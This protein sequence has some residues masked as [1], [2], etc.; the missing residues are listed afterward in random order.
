MDNNGHQFVQYLKRRFPD[1][2]PNLEK[3]LKKLKTVLSGTGATQ[4]AKKI[5]RKYYCSKCGRDFSRKFNMLRHEKKCAQDKDDNIV[6]SLYVNRRKTIDRNAMSGLANIHQ[7]FP[8]LQEMFDILV[9]MGNLKEEITHHLKQRCQELKHL[10]YYLNISVEMTRQTDDGQEETSKPHF[11]TQTKSV[12]SETDI[13]EHM[14]NE[15]FQKIFKSLDEYQR[16]GSSWTLKK[17]ICF[18]IYTAK[19]SPIGAGSF[20]E[21]PEKLRNTRSVINIKNTDEKCFLWSIL[22]A[23]HPVENNKNRVLHYERFEKTVNMD[24]IAYPVPP[25]SVPKFEKQNQISVNVF[26]YENNQVFPLYISAQ[27]FLLHVDLLFLTSNGQSH[28]CLIENFDRFMSHFRK[29]KGY[30]Y[31]RYCLQGFTSQRVLNNHLQFCSKKDAQY[32]TYPRKGEDDEL[33]FTEVAKQ[34]RVPFVIYADFETF[35]QTFD[36]CSPDPETSFTENQLKYEACGYGYQVVSLDAKYTKTPKIYRG[37][38]VSKHFLESMIAERDE[39][40]NILKTV[41]PLQMSNSEELS[42]ISSTQC[43][44]CN[45]P[46]SVTTI[47]VRDHC[48]VSGR[49]RGAACQACNLNYKQPNFIP[50]VFHNL[51][52]FDSHIICESLGYFKNYEIKCI[53]QNSEKYVSFSLGN[54][55][56]I[57]SYQFLGS[58]L[59]TL[60]DNLASDGGSKH[61]HQLKKVFPDANILHLMMRK[62]VY[63]YEYVNEP[64]KF[65]ET[66]LP[67]IEQF[68]SRLTE[69]NISEA[70]Y[71]H[72]QTVWNSLK[73]KNLG[74]YHDLYLKTDVVLLADVFEH[75]RDTILNYFQ[76]DPCHFYTVPGLSWS[77]ALKMTKC[78]LTLLSDPTMYL[79]FEELRGGVSMIANKYAKANNPL[80]E[81]YNP[82]LPNTW[83]QYL[84]AN[85]LYASTMCMPLPT[86]EFRWLTSDEVE[87]FDI[88][89]KPINGSKGYVLE[90]D[91][92][93]PDELHDLHSDLPLAPEHLTVMDEQLSPYTK[94]LYN[95]LRRPLEDEKDSQ[96]SLHRPRTRKLVPNLFKK[97]R[98]VV[99]MRN[100]QMYINLGLRVSKIHRIIEFEQSTWLEPYITF[101]AERRKMSKSKCESNF[102]K[103]LPNSFFGKTCEDLRKRID[104]KLVHKHEKFLKEVAKSSFKGFRIFSDDLV[105]MEH[106]Q[107]R[108]HLNKP[109]FTGFCILDMSKTIIYDFHYNH[110]KKKYPGSKLKLLWTDT[111]SLGYLIQTRDLY[112]D[113]MEDLH[114]YDTSN[115]PKEHVLYS[116]ENERKP[117]VMKDESPAKPIMEYVGLRSKM[118]AFICN[119]KEEVKIAKGI[120]KSA[121]S[122]KLRFQQYKKC[123]LEKKIYMCEFSNISHE[124]HQLYLTHFNKIGLSAADDKRYVLENGFDCVA[125]GHFNFRAK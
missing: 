43:H 115:F 71:N 81:E 36:T 53:A 82:S 86:G 91:L 93:Y 45:D 94:A 12:L 99:H 67:S 121:I 102:F 77:A 109:I 41:Q 15:G 10:K 56:F 103:L 47:K 2:S 69:S 122:K 73:I 23:L 27:P 16:K 116:R 42:F 18:E 84:D 111:D 55:R 72:A 25:S 6:E 4:P 98:Y 52:H 33:K 37:P 35:C 51:K 80:V 61:F 63:C 5:S 59:E 57:D 28:W 26:G 19:Y 58:S 119:T 17:I 24:G 65:N 114:L 32:V 76:L 31:C 11:R 120:K 70:D 49:Y 78:K 113:M 75:F 95:N 20:L 9:F 50:V 68:F 104:F 110:M 1:G 34:V 48:H 97:D 124:K 105:G 62:G 13:N 117:G 60:V 118:Y 29:R 74:E 3:E 89:S 44:I 92:L 125:L 14:L 54:L 108:L 106:V 83:I 7:I 88:T 8:H 101:N 96:S 46:F 21:L 79:F 38:N 87:H 123:L 64:S 112:A 39:I 85:A 107:V 66:T 100:L 30:A 40:E 90:V 22:A